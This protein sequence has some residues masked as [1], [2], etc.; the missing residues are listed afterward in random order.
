MV[1]YVLAAAARTQAAAMIKELEAAHSGALERLTQGALTE[2]RTWP[3]LTVKD[4]AEGE[5]EKGCSVAGAYDYGPP[6]HLS[7]ATS[8]SHA[9][10]DFTALHE[11]GHH[12]QKNS[13]ALMEPFSREPD[14]G[15]LLED[16]ACDAFAAEI[17]LPAPTVNLYL[18]PKGPTASAIT[19]LWRASNAS[20]MAVCVR[21]A[22]HLPAPG[23]ILLL[24]TTGHL[25]FAAS[26]GLPPLRRGSFQGD[27]PVIDRA[28]TGSGHVQGVTQVRYRDGILGREL[29]TDTAPMNGYLVAVLVT[30]SAPWRTFTPPTRD[31]GPQARDYICANCDEEYR[32]FEP[33][34]Q[35]CRTPQCPDCGRCACPPRVTERHCPGCFTLHPPAMFPPDSDRCLD[36][37]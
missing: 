26:H 11:L 28:L 25:A 35:R 6:P 24:D 20:R 16:A 31:T 14:A 22:Q 21:A 37:S 30:D 4:V 34:C 1:N 32:S 3:E 29:H 12:L 7:V 2:L 15:L 17:L 27:I 36:C 18:A 13:F 10:R 23:H 33:A 5:T 9:R 19:H 8:A